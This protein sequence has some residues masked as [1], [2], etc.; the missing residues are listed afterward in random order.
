MPD[1]GSRTRPPAEVSQRKLDKTVKMSADMQ[2][3]QKRG[4][5]LNQG[6][7]DIWVLFALR[8]G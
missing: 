1:C 2:R 4:E 8:P 5:W 3:E 6:E 7:T